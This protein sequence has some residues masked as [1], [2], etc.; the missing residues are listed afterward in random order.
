MLSITASERRNFHL[1]AP[2]DRCE[3]HF[4]DFA[5]ML[6]DLP[7]VRLV[8]TRAPG[9]HRVVYRVTIANIYQVS[10]YSDVRARFDTRARALVVEPDERHTTVLPK[11]TL[12]SL[13]GQGEYRSRLTLRPSGEGTYV[14]YQVSLSAEVPT[15]VALRLLPAAVA[16]RAVRSVVSERLQHTIDQFIQRVSSRLASGELRS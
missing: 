1:N 4:S 2:L 13:T 16:R 8:Q 10:L 3:A 15:P 11:A 6:E 5:Q 9:R 14:S 12:V 7:D